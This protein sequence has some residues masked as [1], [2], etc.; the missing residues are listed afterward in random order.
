MA[1]QF[2]YRPLNRLNNEIRLLRIDKGIASQ[3]FNCRIIHA[4]LD[5]NPS[6]TAFSYVWKPVDTNQLGMEDSPDSSINIEGK[7]LRV[8]QNL[9]AAIQYLHNTTD[10]Y[11]WID[12]ICIDQENPYERGQEVL[13]MKRIYSGA[14]R[15]LVWLGSEAHSSSIAMD[16]L[17]LLAER[18]STADA[19]RWLESHATDQ[20]NFFV[21]NALYHLLKRAWW[22]R[23]WTMQEFVLGQHT[24]FACGD[25]QL[26]AVQVE[27]ALEL[28]RDCW[29]KL[30]DKPTLQ[31]LDFNARVLE[32][33]I[34]LYHIRRLLRQKEGPPLLARLIL[35]R[36]ARASDGRDH[37]YAKY[38]ILGE[39][40]AAL[41]RP[42]YCQSELA[43]CKTFTHNYIQ[44]QK[45]LYIVCLA[46]M[47]PRERGSSFPTWLPDWGPAK[48]TYPLQC[49]WEENPESPKF[50]AA[51]GEEAVVQ[52]LQQGLVLKCRAIVFDEVD[53]VQFDPWAHKVPLEQSIGS[54]SQYRN[55][56]YDTKASLFNALFRTLV[57]NT[58]RWD[59]P[60]R[61]PDAFGV[62]F[63]QKCQE[64]DRLLESVQ[65]PRGQLPTAPRE[66]ALPIE[67]RWHGMRDLRLGD[68]LL[69]DVVEQRSHSSDEQVILGSVAGVAQPPR[70]SEHPLWKPFEHSIGQA[71]F[72]R[73]V[74]TTQ[75]GY[76]GLGPRTLASSDRICVLLGCSV[77]VILRPNAENFSLI[78]EAYVHGIMNGE[79]LRAVEQ[80]QARIRWVQL[81]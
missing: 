28:L 17:A 38:A 40:A 19:H 45:D 26:E 21:W 15:V 8:T 23:A 14:A 34:N 29:F 64:Y 77:P 48:P 79:V 73:R 58:N 50:D 51:R 75:K 65:T 76:L 70:L 39:S 47:A 2:T 13:R 32:P 36:S 80:G 22:R 67:K 37:L 46:G 59:Q 81:R 71:M 52:F 11:F 16:F 27:S 43:V 20:V 42:D 61:A 53:G 68:S 44:A 55:C 78:G 66:N 74:F 57:A 63:A 69:R 41:C 31:Q 30:F 33:V 49:S 25:R 10:S 7:A 9:E 24:N 5:E 1:S 3:Q 35:T 6:Y 62:L 18:A 54:Q 60:S 56:I 12:A 4:S 72:Q